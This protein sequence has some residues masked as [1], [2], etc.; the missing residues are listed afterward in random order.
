M[1]TYEDDETPGPG[2]YEKNSSLIKKNFRSKN[3]KYSNIFFSKSE[4]F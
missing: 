4:R 3:E 1:T 2:Y